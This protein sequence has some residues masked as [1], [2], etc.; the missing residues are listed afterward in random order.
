MILESF[1]RCVAENELYVE[2][3][4]LAGGE[5]KAPTPASGIALLNFGIDLA[6]LTR[7]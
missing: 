7:H 5:V 2:E 3:T 6:L 1:K 4:G